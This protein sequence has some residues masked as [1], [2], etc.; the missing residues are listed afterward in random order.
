MNFLT[1]YRQPLLGAFTDQ[2]EMFTVAGHTQHGANIR[3]LANR[4]NGIWE[5]ISTDIWGTPSVLSVYGDPSRLAVVYRTTEDKLAFH[6]R[7]SV[8]TWIKTIIPSGSD[9]KKAIGRPVGETG[10]DFNSFYVVSTFEDGSVR[11]T[12][13]KPGLPWYTLRSLSFVKR[14]LNTPAIT[15]EPYSGTINSRMWVVAVTTDGE[16]TYWRF[17]QNLPSAIDNPNDPSTYSGSWTPQTTVPVGSNA[18]G[19]A[20]GTPAIVSR[21]L[22]QVD[23]IYRDVNGWLYKTSFT[24][25]VWGPAER[26]TGPSSSTGL[27]VQA[28]GNPTVVSRVPSEFDVF[29]SADNGYTYQIHLPGHTTRVLGQPTSASTYIQ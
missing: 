23:I 24:S 26:L 12:R 14:V 29:F 3:G 5:W 17:T 27:D 22:G 9:G 13:N 6:L 18:P 1:N 16:L 21:V 7:T 19:G 11:W 4:R 15:R 28:V 8:Y 25:G 10:Y 2:P 20:V